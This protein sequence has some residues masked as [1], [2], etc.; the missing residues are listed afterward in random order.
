MF[1][2][3]ADRVNPFC[4]CRSLNICEKKHG[5]S[6]HIV[7]LGRPSVNSLVEFPCCYEFFCPLGVSVVDK[8]CVSHESVSR[9]ASLWIALWWSMSSW[10]SATTSSWVASSWESTASS[11]TRRTSSGRS[12]YG[13]PRWGKPYRWSKVKRSADPWVCR[14]VWSIQSCCSCCCC[15]ICG[16]HLSRVWIYSADLGCDCFG[17]YCGTH[18]LC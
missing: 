16:K 2:P 8:G 9:W 12:E 1:K 4:G 11:S 15:I 17:N 6:I 13:V 3:V 7:H 5:S 10:K 18:L 14:R